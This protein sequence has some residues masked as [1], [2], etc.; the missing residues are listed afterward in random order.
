MKTKDAITDY[1]LVYKPHKHRSGVNF[2]KIQKQGIEVVYAEN[3]KSMI[4]MM[5]RRE[6]S[7]VIAFYE[8]QDKNAIDFLR[9][10]MRQYPNTQRIYITSHIQNDLIE[11]VINKAHVNY[12][13]VLPVKTNALIVIIEKAFKRYDY[14]TRPSKRYDDLTDITTELVKNVKKYKREAIIDPLTKLYNRRSFDTLLN[15]ME[16]LF[17]EKQFTFSI[18]LMDLDDFKRVNDKYGHPAGDEVLRIFGQILKKNMRQEDSAFRYGGE[19]FA[20][21]AS[22]DISEN[23][24]LFVNRIRNEIKDTVVSYKKIKINF[25]FS[26]GIACMNQKYSKEQLIEAADKAL[27]YAKQHGKDQVIVYEDSLG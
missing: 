8:S 6:A 16:D 4:D 22:G 11:K 1:L 21:I 3:K 23:I 18:V 20:I 13:L 7:A 17:R 12:L 2:N 5:N 9:Y 26:A 10:I 27:Y 24:K 19:E 25:T 15:K 14:L